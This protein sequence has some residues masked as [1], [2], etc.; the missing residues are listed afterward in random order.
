MTFKTDTTKLGERNDAGITANGHQELKM[1]QPDEKE[2]LI[3]ELIEIRDDDDELGMLVDAILHIRFEVLLGIQNN[4]EEYVENAINNVNSKLNTKFKK[5]I[6]H[7]TKQ[8]E[9]NLEKL[10]E[11]KKVTT[12]LNDLVTIDG[13]QIKAINA[14]TTQLFPKHA[15]AVKE[16]MS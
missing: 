12:Q 11:L 13:S 14:T 2:G 1:I 6:K 5:K 8:C 7:L 10:T 9:H 16:L 3:E 4:M 15:V